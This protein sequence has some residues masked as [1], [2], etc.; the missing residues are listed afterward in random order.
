MDDS[1]I[2]SP[3]LSPKFQIYIFNFLRIFHVYI[4]FTSLCGCIISISKLI[5]PKSNSWFFCQVHMSYCLAHLC[6]CQLHISCCELC[7]PKT[8][9]SLLISPFLTC[10]FQ[11]V[12]KLLWHCIEKML[13]SNHFSLPSLL[14]LLT[15]C[16]HF[17][18][19]LQ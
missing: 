14:P 13:E 8:L 10:P 18:V 12:S 16:H 9:E 15:R 17:S 7:R 4:Q 3:D 5:C 1:H 6:K 19:F 11:S 2:Y